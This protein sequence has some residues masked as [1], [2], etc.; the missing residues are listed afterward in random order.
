MGISIHVFTNLCS[1]GI[2]NNT[3]MYQQFQTAESDTWIG[4]TI[5]VL[6]NAPAMV[7]NTF[8]LFLVFKSRRLRMLENSFMVNLVAFDLACSVTFPGFIIYWYM[9]LTTP[10]RITA[11]FCMIIL[12]TY[13]TTGQFGSLTAMALDRYIKII[14]PFT[15]TRICNKQYVCWIFLSV[16]LLSGASALGFNLHFTWDPRD[17]CFVNYTFPQSILIIY[18]MIVLTGLL[19]VL[20]FNVNIL[21]VSIQQKKQIHVM[22]RSSSVHSTSNA[23][24]S[25]NKILGSLTLF[26]FITYLPNWILLALSAAGITIKSPAHDFITMATAL[27]WNLGVLVDPFGVSSLSK[28][29]QSLCKQFS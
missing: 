3:T 24:T 2:M 29:H 17:A 10:Q 15:H 23:S 9:Y 16:H 25:S 11:C 27:L 13:I 5:I 18:Q 26:T 12:L 7:F 1:L 8:L 19:T 14:H 28:R 4:A 21:Y 6:L 22:R 20:I